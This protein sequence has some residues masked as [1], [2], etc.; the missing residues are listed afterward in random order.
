MA[1]GD[2]F[3]R[4][5][6]TGGILDDALSKSIINANQ[7]AR[8]MDDLQNAQ[9]NIYNTRKKMLKADTDSLNVLKRMQSV[10]NKVYTQMKKNKQVKDDI[11]DTDDQIR[12]IE[13]NIIKYRK[14]GNQEM[15]KINTSIRNQLKLQNEVNKVQLEQMRKT[16]DRK[17]VV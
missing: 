7:H 2:L 13:L 3:S 5:V 6:Q 11:L 14:Q 17:S 12:K 4:L 9:I 10:H 1:Q 15:V 16:I 8:A